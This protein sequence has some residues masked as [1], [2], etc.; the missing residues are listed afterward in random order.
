MIVNPL[1]CPSTQ[2]IVDRGTLNPLIISLY[3][4]NQRNIIV[5]VA[6]RLLILTMVLLFADIKIYFFTILYI[7]PILH[8]ANIFQKLNPS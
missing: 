7:D 4:F 6:I 5:L 1:Q 2:V 8:Y 3:H